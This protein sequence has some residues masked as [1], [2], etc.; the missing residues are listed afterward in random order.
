[1]FIETQGQKQGEYTHIY[2][3]WKNRINVGMHWTDQCSV[4]I[5]H[6]LWVS[7]KSA[8]TK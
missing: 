3:F 7:K 4:Q 2:A 6:P 1:M 8:T 5:S